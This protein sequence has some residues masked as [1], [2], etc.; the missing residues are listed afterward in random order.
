[1]KFHRIYTFIL[2]VIVSL[3]ILSCKPQYY[4]TNFETKT[5]THKIIAVLPIEM[6]F[7]GQ[8]P[9][10]WTLDDIRQIEEAESQAFQISFY[11]EILRSTKSGRKP[12]RVDIQHYNKT[13]QLLEDHEIGIRESWRMS[14]EKLAL[15]LG[16]DAVV[17]ARIKKTRFMSD[18]ESYGIEVATEIVNII[19]D[20][21][22]F[23]FIPITA[24]NKEIVAD[25]AVVDKNDGI[26][27]W[28]ISFKVGADWRQPAN[29]IIDNISRRA[30]RNFPYRLK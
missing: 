19:T 5:A 30:A 4:A 16:V 17:S 6:H 11:N 18:L 13:W 10:K 14:R 1:M 15:V 2:L 22:M 7:I 25:Y 9:E 23:P 29:Q 28:S 21:K 24:Q 27:L 3:L 12:I 20:H 8:I 26:T